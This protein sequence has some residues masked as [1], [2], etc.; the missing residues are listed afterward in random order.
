MRLPAEFVSQFPGG[1]S[2]A[3]AAIPVI[4][5]LEEPLKAEVRD[6]FGRSLQVVWQVSIGI[7]GIGLLASFMMKGLPLHT[8]MDE[9]WAL[10][11]GGKGKGVTVDAEKQQISELPVM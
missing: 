9:K 5:T 8:E 7:S 10:E 2:I 6:A 4:R 1:V 3:Y 11:D